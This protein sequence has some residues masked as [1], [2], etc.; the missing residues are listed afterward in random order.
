MTKKE[1]IRLL[2]GTLIMG[3]VFLAVAAIGWTQQEFVINYFYGFDGKYESVIVKKGFQKDPLEPGR[4]GHVFD[5]WYYLDKQGNEVLFDFET[6]RVT[7]NLD[8]TAHWEPFETE[9]IF[10]PTGG[11]CDVESMTVPYGT[12]FVLPTP[13]KKGYY[14]VGWGSD[15]G[16]LWP[17]EATWEHPLVTVRFKACWSKFKP[18]TVYRLGEYEQTAIYDNE[19]FVGWQREPIEWIPVDKIDGKYLLVSKD[20]IDYRT[21]SPEHYPV[22]WQ[23]TELR[24]WLNEE[25]YYNVFTEEERAVICDFTDPEFGTTDKV[26]ILSLE[27]AK[28]IF[29]LERYVSGTDYARS[30]GLEDPRNCTEITTRFGEN[31]IFYPWLTRSFWEGKNWETTGSAAGGGWAHK[32]GL[33]PAILVDPEKLLNK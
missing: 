12:D 2:I 9:F 6:E 4:Y 24:R 11:D 15:T 26:F 20:I 13:T 8:L 29:G 31:Y 1:R 19:V 25:F 17:Q 22:P 21:L 16:W 27:E 33:R 5:G 3:A 7:R 23:N 10:N 18:G 30:K 28:L 32:S 14:F